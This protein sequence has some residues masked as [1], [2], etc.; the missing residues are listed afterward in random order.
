M[1]IKNKV[2]AKSKARGLVRQAAGAA[3]GGQWMREAT[4]DNEAGGRRLGLKA[5]S[6]KAMCQ[7]MDSARG[8][9]YRVLGREGQSDL[10]VNLF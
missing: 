4:A 5:E 10:D 3:K 9:P 8:K 1:G 6:L 7:S 2:A